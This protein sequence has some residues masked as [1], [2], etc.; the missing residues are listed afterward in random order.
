MGWGQLIG[1][2]A[3]FLLGGPAGMALGASLGGAAEEATG[4]GATG[5]AREAAQISNA[6]AERDLALR[7]R[8]YEEGI[9]RQKP[10][11]EAGVNALPS[12]VSGIQEGGELVRG[13]NMGDFTADPGYAFRLSEGQKGLERTA[14][15]RGGLISGSALKAA[16]RYGQEM[17]SQEFGN[18]YNRFRETQG[19]RRN[20]LAGVAGYGPTAAT[21]M[22]A[23]GQNYATGAGNIMSGQGETSANALIAGQQARSSSYGQLGSALGRYLNPTSSSPSN[24]DIERMMYGG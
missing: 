23:A 3:G 11:Y 6:A 20:A 8:M 2:G 1:A 13:F 17:G 4:G 16:Q 19:L 7:T 5:A 10:F 24:A 12:Y 21:S 9:A 15:A 22:N 14:A 18:A